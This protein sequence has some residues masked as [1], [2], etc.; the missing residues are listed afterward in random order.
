MKYKYSLFLL[1]LNLI[2]TTNKFWCKEGINC[3]VDDTFNAT[4]IK[5]NLIKGKT[6]YLHGRNGY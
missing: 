6:V 1:L 4:C 3:G 5:I 2:D